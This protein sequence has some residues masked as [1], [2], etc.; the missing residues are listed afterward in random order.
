MEEFN[1]IP[2]KRLYLHYIHVRIIP[3]ILRYAYPI[4]QHRTIFLLS[5]RGTTHPP[6]YLYLSG[7]NSCPSFCAPDYLME[8]RL[9]DR[10]RGAACHQLQSAIW[11]SREQQ[12]R[13]V[14]GPSHMLIWTS[15][16]EQSSII[17]QSWKDFACVQNTVKDT[18]LWAK[19]WTVKMTH[20]LT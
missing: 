5:E 15:R 8:L 1:V 4:L 20:F 17:R 9:H 12:P 6:N 13:L 7:I 16:M 2:E 11:S 3:E 18:P 19:L 14:T 10:N